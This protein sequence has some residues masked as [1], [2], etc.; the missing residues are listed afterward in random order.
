VQLEPKYWGAE[1]AESKIEWYFTI[2]TINDIDLKKKTGVL[3]LKS[4]MLKT[5]LRP[6]IAHLVIPILIL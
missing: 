4:G 3:K 5:L 1:I 6:L 2:I